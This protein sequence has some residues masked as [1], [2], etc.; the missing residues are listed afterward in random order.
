MKKNIFYLILF[1]TI[2]CHAQQDITVALDTVQI[3]I[4]EQIQYTIATKEKEEVRFP[5]LQNLKGL[6][7]ISAK[8]VDTFAN[9][10]ERK[11]LLTCF[12][13]GSYF[14]PKQEIFIQNKAYYTDSLLVHV[15]TVTVDTL[16]QKPF[17]PKPIFEEP[18]VFDDYRP[19]FI[20]L[21]VL[22]AVLLVGGAIYFLL[23][24]YYQEEGALEIKKVPPYQEA[25]QKFASL[26]EK[27]LWQNNKT[28]E[29]YIELTEIVRVYLAREI[30]IP[31]LE[32]TSDELIQKIT[33]QNQTKE[34]G[35]S[36]EVIDS[37]HL[38]L[39]HAD[40]VKFAQL[41]PLVEEIK[42]NSTEAKNI[43]E[44][45]QPIMEQY[46]EANLL[47]DDVQAKYLKSELEMSPL[48]KRKRTI[49]YAIYVII[50]ALILTFGTRA[51]LHYSNLFGSSVAETF[52][53]TLNNDNWQKQSFGDPALILHA[54]VE[55]PLQTNEVPLQVQNVV[56]SLGRYE[57]NASN[58]LTITINTLTYAGTNAN[59][60][61]VLQ[62]TV[63]NLQSIPNVEDFEYERLPARFNNGLQGVCLSGVMTKKGIP[64]E[65]KIIGVAN[66][67]NVW[68]VVSVYNAEDTKLK[69]M[70]ETMIASITIEL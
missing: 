53:P 66:E 40:F 62:N 54:P 65:F 14:I 55:I 8:K 32:A 4:G 35:I 17:P 37:L 58:E 13:S 29:Y 69:T 46:K 6:E 31:S 57:Y 26:E 7:L 50:V 61:G 34:I 22:L 2:L 33:T 59:I 3:R 64:K 21:W 9:R 19:Y 49:L 36:K 51:I 12:D 20:W 28:K 16:K 18:L 41:R 39:K 56:T 5:E 11:Y 60:E 47:T 45:L 48:A 30:K 25:I 43:I 70:I 44:S 68:Q 23:K 67:K 15:A 38:F 10:L 27:Q 42:Q 1:C 24:K 52:S 63:Q